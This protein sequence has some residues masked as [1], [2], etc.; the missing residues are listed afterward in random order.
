MDQTWLQ[1]HKYHT[2][3]GAYI[4]ITG[5]AILRIS[6]QPYSR[7]IKAEQ[8]ESIF[9]GTTL[10]AV[11]VGIAMNGRLNKARSHER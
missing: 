1:R 10:G 4:I 3:V 8:I 6:R 9:K 11:V 5:V 7:N 2:L